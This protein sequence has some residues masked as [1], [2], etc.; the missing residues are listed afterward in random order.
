MTIKNFLLLFVALIAIVCNNLAPKTNTDKTEW[1]RDAKLGMFIHW[2][3]YSVPA[4]EYNNAEICG[5]GKWII[6]IRKIQVSNYAEYAKQFNPEK[7]NL[8]VCN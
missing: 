6:N 8:Y 3:L 4:G 5:L 1:W 7:F 2:V